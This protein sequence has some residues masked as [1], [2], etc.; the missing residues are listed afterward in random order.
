M[1]L[2][3][4]FL[5]LLLFIAFPQ[6]SL[7]IL[8]IFHS[9]FSLI[10]LLLDFWYWINSQ[11]PLIS[12]NSFPF[13]SLNFFVFPFAR[14]PVLYIL[15]YLP[16]CISLLNTSGIIFFTIPLWALSPPLYPFGI[17]R[18]FWFICVLHYSHLSYFCVFFF[19]FK[20]A[21]SPELN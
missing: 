1:I 14:P 12:C 17:L 6:Y 10:F 5:S 9:I 7:C 18:V 16:F 20:F 11:C 15:S 19:F 21:L 4:T 8:S 2:F 3:W 13:V